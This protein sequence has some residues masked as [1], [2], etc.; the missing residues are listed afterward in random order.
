MTDF[1]K[2]AFG[3]LTG[4]ISGPEN[5]F[6]GQVVELGQQK[7]RV[8]R[9]IAEGGY[10]FVYV[11]QDVATGKDYALKRLLAHDKEKNQM[12][13]DEIKYL[14]KLTG[15]P[16]I[17]QFIAAASDSD[18]G[19]AEYLL[20]TELCTGQ[21]VDVL[22][23]AGS[24]LPCN[25]VI[26]IFY[27]TCRAVQHMHRQN[28]PIIHRDLKAENLLISSKHMIK[29]CDFG[30]AT[31]TAHFPDGSW[32]AI[33]RS[34]V[35]DEIAKNTTPMYRA[36]EMLD[37][38]Q[39]FPICEASDVWA[40]GCLLYM[41]CFGNHPFEDSAKLRIIN[42]NYSIPST[43]TQYTVLHDLIKSMLQVDPNDR[44]TVHDLVD[45]LQEIAIAKNVN[46][47]GPLH[48][49]E[50]IPANIV[51]DSAETHRR[52]NSVFYDEGER[53][54]NYPPPPTQNANASS[55]FNSLRGG[56]G[57]LMKNIKDASA[58][59]IETVSATMGKTDLDINY[60]TSRIAVMSF[61]AEGVEAAFKNNIDEVRSYLESRHKDCYAVYN[62][63]QRTYRAI[64]FENRV[65]ECGWP[66]KK[67]PL[68]TSLFEVCKNMLLWL[69]QNPKN[70]CVIHCIDGK[71][72]SATVVGAFLSFVHLFESP[73]QSIH[74][75]SMKRGPPGVTPSQKRYIGYIS[76]MV[77]DTP[78]VPHN[79]AV[80]LKS[81]TLSPV[82]LFNKMRNGCRPFVEV[83]VDEERI[84]TT[85]QEYEKMKGYQTEDGSAILPVNTTAL[86]DVTVVVY[87]ARSTFGGKVQ[88]KITSMKMFQVQ[89]NTG[90]VRPGTTS[91]KFTQ[92]DLDQL[93]TAE[94]YPEH[95]CVMLDL[96]VSKN[97]RPTTKVQPWKSLD[98]SKLSPKILFS[99]KEEMQETFRDYGVTKRAKS[100]L[101]R[102]SSQGSSGQ[103]SPEH[104][105]N[106]QPSTENQDQ[107]KERI[108]KYNEEKSKANVASSAASFLSSLS[109]QNSHQEENPEKEKPTGFVAREEGEGLLSGSDDDDAFAALSEQ[110]SKPVNAETLLDFSEDKS[111]IRNTE[112]EINSSDLGEKSNT[113]PLDQQQTFDPFA[114]FS[115]LNLNNDVQP[116][117][118]SSSTNENGF[119]FD[120]FQDNS[121]ENLKPSGSVTN[122][123]NLLD[124]FSSSTEQLPTASTKKDDMF[125]FLD[126]TSSGSKDDVNLLGSW[127]IHN[128]KDSIPTLN[129]PRN[130]SNSS[131]HQSSSASNFQ[132]FSGMGNANIPRN[133][134][135]TFTTGQKQPMFGQS[136]SGN[137][138]PLT[139]GQN[140]KG[141]ST[142]SAYDPFA[143]FGNLGAGGKSN[144]SGSFPN[145]N[146]P[147]QQPP[148]K[149]SATPGANTQGSPKVTR[150]QNP[151]KQQQTFSKP[152]YNV[153]GFVTGGRDERGARKPFGPKPPVSESAFE[154]LLGNHQF[155]SSK[156]NS[157]PKT[158]GAMKKKQ[159]AEEMDPDKLKV[160]DWIEG[161]ERNV[162]ALLCSLDKVLWDGEKRWQQV[163][164]HDL[165]TADQVKKVYRK[166]VL[167]VHPDK[168]GGTPHEALAKLIFIELNDAWAQ[169][170]EE[171]MK[172]L[173]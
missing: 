50:N 32:S 64:K 77:A 67:A 8:R 98:G 109:W 173:Y 76:D 146:K 135:G 125:D 155:T 170:E 162:R 20:L 132:Q 119:L 152:N 42:A 57:N 27:Q 12:V 99:N 139:I 10:A 7:L 35:E 128:V 102:S 141:Q 145:L 171:G 91:M 80:L 134:S 154:D 95:F 41:L 79:C 163:G 16:N 86:G 74:M 46:L 55:I 72:S 153:G 104:V 93:D 15:H 97:E 49:A 160:L 151:P 75:F 21:L 94:K 133:S 83:Y 88:G 85:S 148:P 13:I 167:S 150:P 89:F 60:I 19:Q 68:L 87:H 144:F 31:T 71:A 4:N 34:L 43:D 100:Q 101:S 140:V 11:A 30:S 106:K 137:N 103:T 121:S 158:L 168:L 48:I 122:V 70:I 6:V 159:R 25:D 28:P 110:R 115:S 54:E 44:P 58:K 130:P 23:S 52:P 73:E 116:N 131:M 172:S 127:D 123:D 24:P 126:D 69:R 161:K 56:A 9:V 59:V 66:P 92:F 39:N 47:K 45:R 117:K 65:S 17:V 147:S 14:K 3:V 164:M 96:A 138:S 78:Y 40:L 136:R 142:N 82:P 165:V 84:L 38:Y 169:F 18:K 157:T 129:I 22:N 37:L 111:D 113:E 112:K 2:S 29:L 33:Q 149:P 61:P 36:P 107:R 1:F 5:D 166:A 143:E 62:L 51:I 81:M 90:M 124:S 108:T 156:Q 120:A 26:Q 114:D 63:S 105:P 53:A 118:D